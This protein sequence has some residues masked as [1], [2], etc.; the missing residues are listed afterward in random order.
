M[1]LIDLL[2]TSTFSLVGNGFNA[3]STQGS[4]TTPSWG[5]TDSTNNLDP[6]VSKLHNTYDVDGKPTIR[7]ID[8]NKDGQ[9]TVKAQSNLDELDPNAPKNTKA[10]ALS[11]VVSQ[12]YK[13]STGQGYKSKG[14]KD[15][16]Y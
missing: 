7:L 9:S 15:G 3:V 16:R 4:T 13:S 2:K 6:S 14:P 12:I 1:A 8:F 5:Y 11:S 10:G